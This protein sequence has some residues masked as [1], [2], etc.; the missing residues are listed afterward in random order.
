ML[1]NPPRRE[2]HPRRTRSFARRSQHCG[3][4]Q[5]NDLLGQV[6]AAALGP[7]GT[8]FRLDGALEE[9]G[10]LSDDLPDLLLHVVD[11]TTLFDE[12]VAHGGDPI[13]YALP[14]AGSDEGVEDVTVIGVD[15]VAADA[16][17]ARERSD[18]QT[19]DRSGGLF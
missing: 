14:S 19:S 4:A 8:A 2:R 18:G 7:L 6:G 13:R 10:I 11:Y 15:G 16:R 5:D 12:C 9:A 3:T 17:L 1:V